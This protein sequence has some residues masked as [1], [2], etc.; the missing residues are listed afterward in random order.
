M[1]DWRPCNN[2]MELPRSRWGH[3]SLAIGGFISCLSCHW[4]IYIISLLLL[5]GSYHVSLAIG[6]FI[7]CLSWC[8]W[9]HIMS[10]LL[11]VGL[12]YSFTN[13]KFYPTISYKSRQ[14]SISCTQLSTN[15]PPIHSMIYGKKMKQEISTRN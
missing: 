5:V 9:V 10:L 14:S 7:S 12:F 8:W 1:L 6:G 3:V 11:L 13:L 2:S 15:T 4:W